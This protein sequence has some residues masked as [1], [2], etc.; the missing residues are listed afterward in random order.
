MAAPV[1]RSRPGE[2]LVLIGRSQVEYLHGV[3]QWPFLNGEC[4]NFMGTE[5]DGGIDSDCG[6]SFALLQLHSPPCSARQSLA[7]E[8]LEEQGH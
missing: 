4:I 2:H 7:S 1:V 6:E 3:I 5:D 8:F